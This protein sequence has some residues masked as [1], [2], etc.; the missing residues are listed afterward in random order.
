MDLKLPDGFVSLQKASNSEGQFLN[1]M[2]VVADFL[3]ITQSRGTGKPSEFYI[4]VC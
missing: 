2:G 1:L 3:P 4:V